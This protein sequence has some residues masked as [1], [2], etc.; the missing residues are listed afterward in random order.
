MMSPSRSLGLVPIYFTAHDVA[1]FSGLVGRSIA[2][3]AEAMDAW[4]EH[5]ADMIALA[6]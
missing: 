4:A 5:K 1:S 2:A 3:T 6:G